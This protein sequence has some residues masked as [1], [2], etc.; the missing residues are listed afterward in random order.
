MRKKVVYNK[1]LSEQKK[2]FRTPVAKPTT[3]FRDK[4][5]YKRRPKNGEIE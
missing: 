1:E 3:W 4:S 5:K 2:I